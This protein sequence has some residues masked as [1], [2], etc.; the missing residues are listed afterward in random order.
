MS[1][2]INHDRRHFI[3]AVAMTAAVT[4]ASERSTFMCQQ[5]SR[6]PERR[7]GKQYRGRQIQIP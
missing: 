7:V 3:G 5:S 6:S 2:A 4:N 1:I